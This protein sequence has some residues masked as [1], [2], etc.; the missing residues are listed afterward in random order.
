MFYNE[1][2]SI[3]NNIQKEIY[4]INDNIMIIESQSEK[5]NNNE[6]ENNSAQKEKQSVEVVEIEKIVEEKK[7]TDSNTE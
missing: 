6:S 2:S 4:T 5:I 3:N 7:G 1:I